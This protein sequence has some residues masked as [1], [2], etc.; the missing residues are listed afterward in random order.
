MNT[1]QGIRLA[2]EVWQA[3]KERAQCEGVTLEVWL[4]RQL[5]FSA[6]HVETLNDQQLEDVLLSLTI[7]HFKRLVLEPDEGKTLADAILATIVDGEPHRVGPIGTSERHY[8]LRRRASAMTI[9]IGEG[10]VSLPLRSAARLAVVLD[11]TQTLSS[12]LAKLAA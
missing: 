11:N 9:Q 4:E 7:E 2:S 8:V 10:E 6:A 5:V 3:V 1:E 12:A